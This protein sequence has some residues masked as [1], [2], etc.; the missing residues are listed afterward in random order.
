MSS[1]LP[2]LDLIKC[3]S[4]TFYVRYARDYVYAKVPE[5]SSYF[6]YRFLM[7]SS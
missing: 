6:Y 3:L 5:V 7:P 1:I 2:T 4:Q